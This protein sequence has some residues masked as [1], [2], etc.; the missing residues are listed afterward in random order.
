MHTSMNT[1]KR[2]L[3]ACASASGLMLAAHSAYAVDCA[4]LTP[5]PVYVAGSSAVQPFL[6]GL[7]SALASGGQFTIVYQKAGSCTGGDAIINGTNMTGTATYWGSTSPA[8]GETC[9]LPTAGQKA[10]IGVSDVY[11]ESCAAS[12]GSAPPSTV[13][14]FYG[15]VQVM[16]FV[17][18]KA[19]QQTSISAEAA[20]L[21]F[22]FGQ[23]GATPWDDESLMFI[24]N[25]GSGTQSMLAKAINV[26]PDSWKGADQGGSGGVLTSVAAS[27]S[28]DKTIGILS[29]GESDGARDEMKELYY[30]AYGQTCGFLPDSSP[31]SFDKM[32][33]RDG[34]YQVWGPLHM[35]A[36]VDGTGK[37]TNAK[38][39]DLIDYVAGTKALT[40]VNIVDV[41]IKAHLIPQCAMMVKRDTEDGPLMSY[42]PP[43]ACGCYFGKQTDGAAPSGCQTCSQDSDCTT[44]PNTH[45]N[46]GYC[47]AS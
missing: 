30:Q 26:S 3:V 36:N 22:H 47:E 28:P 10:D 46:F 33:V 44:A 11:W 24:R 38:A 17:V 1:M 16:T 13:G 9:D 37:P 31:T 35:Y 20:Y 41:E 8:A 43:S 34:H 32:N 27:T 5:A 12:G 7:G 42:Q 19:S 23:A 21:T 39:S 45:C 2:A 14:N 15:P 18:P 25:A 29:T 6:A 40:G 4:T